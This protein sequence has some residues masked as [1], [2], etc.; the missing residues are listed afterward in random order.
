MI[1]LFF[2]IVATLF[3]LA[4]VGVGLVLAGE[5][6]GFFGVVAVIICVLQLVVVISVRDILHEIRDMRREQK[7]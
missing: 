5:A 4:L 6:Y 3:I 1:Q 2:N 7:K